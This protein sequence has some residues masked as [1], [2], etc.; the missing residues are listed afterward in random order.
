[1]KY[2]LSLVLVLA[3]AGFLMTRSTGAEQEDVKPE[4]IV[5]AFDISRLFADPF[6]NTHFLDF[7]DDNEV[8][9]L[10][11]IERNPD[12]AT[13]KRN[14]RALVDWKVDGPADLIV[15]ADHRL[16]ARDTPARMKEICRAVDALLPRHA[17][18]QLRFALLTSESGDLPPS[19]PVPGT[20]DDRIRILRDGGFRLEWIAHCSVVPSRTY[21]IVT[22]RQTAH[23]ADFEGQIAT[24]ATVLIPITK[25]TRAGIALSF[26]ATEVGEGMSLACAVS[27]VRLK[28]MKTVPLNGLEAHLPDF[29]VGF[30]HKQLPFPGP[31]TD[32]MAWLADGR[33]SVLFVA[34][35]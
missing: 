23:I 7:F 16:I 35:E 2:V 4:I 3:A 22:S 13:L 19:G 34:L 28:N 12:P 21:R 1:M 29:A 30:L 15:T 9:F 32:A 27:D 18:F 17:L 24:M 25:A 31:G 5:K 33:R 10:G 6:D 26:R 14:I 20:L 8:Y 11:S